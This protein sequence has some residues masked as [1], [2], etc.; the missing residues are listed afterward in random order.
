MADQFERYT[1]TPPLHPEPGF[2][3]D[4][5]ELAEQLG[6][7]TSAIAKT[8]AQANI[9]VEIDGDESSWS[10][11]GDHRNGTEYAP[12][13][14][15]LGDP[16]RTACYFVAKP[17]SLSSRVRNA[18]TPPGTRI[19]LP[20]IPRTLA[21]DRQD[22]S[23]RDLHWRIMRRGSL[24]TQEEL[25]TLNA[26]TLQDGAK[27]VASGHIVTNYPTGGVMDAVKNPWQQ[28]LGRI[29]QQV[30]EDARDRVSVVPFRFD[31]FSK[32][33]LIRSLAMARRGMKPNPQTIM[34]RLGRQG[35][36]NEV[37]EDS[38]D[39]LSSHEITAV[40]REQFVTAFGGQGAK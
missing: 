35:S 32:L 9:T 17:F 2:I 21:S 7:A 33:Q 37:L 28:G 12:L 13:L 40:L 39:G 11:V 23:N 36:I 6:S 8:F 24:P 38:V 26:N 15:A 5:R 29:I 25:K 1:T 34:L 22:I 4:A 10:H 3:R 19:N 30:P 31:D 16:G 27:L 20:V 18:L 14:A